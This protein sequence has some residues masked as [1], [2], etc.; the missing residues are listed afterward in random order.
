MKFHLSSIVN[1]HWTIGFVRGGM[2]SVFNDDTLII[3]WIDMPNER[4]FA[5][6]FILDVTDTEILLLVEDFEYAKNKGIISLLHID[7]NT[8][9]IISRKELL[10]LDT[11]LSFPNI[12]RKDCDIYVYP[13]SKQ[14]GRL[15]IYEYNKTEET[16]KY[17]ATICD[18]I[19]WD[20]AIVDYFGTSLLFT[21]SKDNYQL[22][23]YQWDKNSNRFVPYQ[24]VTSAEPNSR[25]GG[26]PFKYMNKYYI[27]S[28]DCSHIYGG[29]LDIKCIEYKDGIFNTEVVK[30]LSSPNR[31]YQLGFHT[32]NEY[33]GVVVVDANGWRYGKIGAF[34]HSVIEFFR[35]LKNK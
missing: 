15:D 2:H 29:A 34:C 5:D 12:L 24:T 14:S 22:D 11:H 26:A 28:Q 4:W 33:K 3:D 27:P 10:E 31:K 7:R 23:I 9:K 17:S 35:K 21:A 20:S 16:L 8:K 1:T 30:H 19:V 32:L 25:L 18:D 13:E 6:P